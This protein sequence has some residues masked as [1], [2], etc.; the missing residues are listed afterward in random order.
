LLRSADGGRSWTRLGSPSGRVTGMTRGVDGRL[1]ALINNELLSS[2]DGGGTWARPGDNVQLSTVAADPVTAGQLYGLDRSGRPVASAD[3]GRTWTPLPGRSLAGL[4]SLT[5]ATSDPLVLFGADDRGVVIGRDGSWGRA[6]G[7]V[8]GAL[9]TNAVRAVV[10]DAGSGDTAQLPGGERVSGALYAA[11]D[12]GVFK[13][14]DY[15]SS[16]FRLALDGDID[17]L[18]VGP[19]GSGLV[20]AISSGGEVYRSTNRGVTWEG[21]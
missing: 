6:S 20:Y 9:P 18:A 8:N 4:R 15:G 10:Y 16:W 19:A 1:Y 11:T 13:S 3:S 17:T 12:S 7:A 21:E 2:G 14:V 5:V